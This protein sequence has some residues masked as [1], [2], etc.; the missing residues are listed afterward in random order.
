MIMSEMRQEGTVSSSSLQRKGSSC[1]QNNWIIFTH[2]TFCYTSELRLVFP[3]GGF[4]LLEAVGISPYPLFTK[5]NREV[6]DQYQ[7]LTDERHHIVKKKSC[8]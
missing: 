3:L 6:E 5:I 1:F 7:S 2:M 4:Y 8:C